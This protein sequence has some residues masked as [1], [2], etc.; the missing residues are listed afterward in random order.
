MYLTL[1]SP[2]QIRGLSEFC[3]TNSSTLLSHF[4]LLWNE[5]SSSFQ[6]LFG[7]YVFKMRNDS[8]SANMT[9]PSGSCFEAKTNTHLWI[10]WAC[11]ISKVK[12]YSNNPS[13]KNGLKVSPI[14]EIEKFEY[15]RTGIFFGVEYCFSRDN[16]FSAEE[17]WIKLISWIYKTDILQ[18]STSTWQ[19]SIIRINSK[20][21][22]YWFESR[23][24]QNP[25]KSRSDSLTTSKNL[26]SWA[27]WNIF[28]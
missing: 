18:E 20:I 8:N 22:S 28:D 27:I 16:L 14:I 2:H 24:S 21:G 19:K 7:T 6:P 26:T 12:N 9:R 11:F 3:K 17:S 13:T 4:L 1:R 5:V 23:E 10:D 15:E 25:I